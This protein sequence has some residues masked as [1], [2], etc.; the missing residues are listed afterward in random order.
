MRG[1]FS[2]MSRSQAQ[3]W[4][5]LFAIFLLRKLKRT[6]RAVLFVIYDEQTV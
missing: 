2:A 3:R 6:A 4:S 5:R 1:A